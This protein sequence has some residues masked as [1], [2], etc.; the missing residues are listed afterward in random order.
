MLPVTSQL[1]LS[2]LQQITNIIK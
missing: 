2:F 1:V